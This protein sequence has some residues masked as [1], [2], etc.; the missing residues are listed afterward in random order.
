LRDALKDKK[1][2]NFNKR[3]NRRQ[4]CAPQSRSWQ[5][6]RE[7][8]VTMLTLSR[9]VSAETPRRHA[10]SRGPSTVTPRH[11]GSRSYSVEIPYHHWPS[12]VPRTAYSTVTPRRRAVPLQKHP[13]VTQH[14]AVTL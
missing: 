13:T 4:K 7:K 12:S 5:N 14:C 11:A 8:L 10:A 2:K 3:P 9:G 1:S 6:S